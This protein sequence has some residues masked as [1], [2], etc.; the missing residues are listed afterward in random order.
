MV[1]QLEIVPQYLIEDHPQVST[2]SSMSRWESAAL[3]VSICDSWRKV[4]SLIMMSRR[5]EMA[6]DPPSRLR[7]PRPAR[8]DDS[9]AGRVMKGLV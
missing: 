7:P 6:W 8:S 1:P 2:L 3:P 9:L 4:L 5:C